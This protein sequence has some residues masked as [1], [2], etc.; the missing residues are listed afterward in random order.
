VGE[1]GGKFGSENPGGDQ[2]G[3]MCRDEECR[4]CM[5]MEICE[6][7][8]IPGAFLGEAWEFPST[9][10]NWK[11]GGY[12]TSHKMIVSKRRPKIPN[13]IVINTIDGR[14]QAPG[15][16]M[17]KSIPNSRAAG[18]LFAVS[19]DVIERVGH[20]FTSDYRICSIQELATDHRP[21]MRTFRS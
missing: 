19:S 13:Q 17:G 12:V 10:A 11:C 1:R 15:T 5:R 3:W 6:I 21:D 20:S 18:V 4:C 16:G 2:W 7:V 9:R 8:C 14:G